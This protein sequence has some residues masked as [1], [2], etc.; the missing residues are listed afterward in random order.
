MRP[1]PDGLTLA[2]TQ[3]ALFSLITGRETGT[4]PAD[5]TTFI[6][7]DARADADERVAV[8]AFMYR[9]RLAEALES[10]FPRLAKLLGAEDFSELCDAYVDAYPSTH[11]S[12]RFLGARFADWLG[13]RFPDGILLG[14]AALEWARDDVFDTA[15]E[16]T[17]SGDD[18]RCWPAERFAELPIRLIQAHRTIE[19]AAG[20]ADLWERSESEAIDCS[21]M[22][23]TGH[24]SLLVWRQGVAVYHRTVETAEREALALAATGT[25]VGRLCEL[26]AVAGDSDQ[27]ARR[28]F[29]WI[30]S[31][32]NDQLLAALP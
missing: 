1:E 18:L 9:A 17:L 28:A 21:A 25:T 23:V 5:P 22:T 30:W 32:A 19:V 12:L 27:A 24:E 6:V 2:A 20:T 16:P 26:A 10:Q 8:Y 4:A 15:D 31:W 29:A 3:S 7:G 13:H 14:L 11:W